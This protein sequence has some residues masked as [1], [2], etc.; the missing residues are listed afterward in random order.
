MEVI[1]II[2]RNN[3]PLPLL[4]C[5]LWMF[6]GKTSNKK[7]LNHGLVFEKVYGVIKF[8]RKKPD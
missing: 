8:N 5:E 4:F 6:V 7:M 3:L 1:E 2:Y